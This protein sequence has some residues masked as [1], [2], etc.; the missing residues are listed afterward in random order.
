MASKWKNNDLVVAEQEQEREV[1]IR[2]GVT[3][4]DEYLLKMI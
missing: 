4:L 1:E 2:M 3:D